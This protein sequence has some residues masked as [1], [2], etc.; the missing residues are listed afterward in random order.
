MVTELEKQNGIPQEGADKRRPSKGKIEFGA[1][2]HKSW[3]PLLI[4]H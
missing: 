4:A 1:V 2:L 3:T